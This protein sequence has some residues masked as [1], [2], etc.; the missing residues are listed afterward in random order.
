MNGEGIQLRRSDGGYSNAG[1]NFIAAMLRDEKSSSGGYFPFSPFRPN[2]PTSIQPRATVPSRE[3]LPLFLF[4]YWRRR[5][6]LLLSYRYSN[7][8]TEFGWQYCE[9]QDSSRE[10]LCEFPSRTN[11]PSI[12]SYVVKILFVPHSRREESCTENMN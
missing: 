4:T 8:I 11:L 1:R 10:V 3:I 6:T 5:R 12:F 9:I 2:L 7:C